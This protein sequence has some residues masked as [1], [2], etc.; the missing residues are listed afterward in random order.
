MS[1][2]DIKGQDRAVSFL[3]STVES[4]RTAH[5]YIF[6]GPAGVG[7]RFAAIKFAMAIQC[8]GRE[9]PCGECVPCR[10]IEKNNHPDVYIL[11]LNG[12]KKRDDEKG[13][14]GI[15]EIREA[16]RSIGLKPYES[17]KKVYIIDGA[18]HM[19][20]EASN[21]LLKTLEEPPSD[22][23]LILIA[24]G[25]DRL[26]PT[27]V[28]RA[29][30]L[31][32]MPLG[33]GYITDILTRFHKVEGSRARILSRIS[34]GSVGK[35]LEYNREDFFRKRENLID[36]L[37]KKDVL[38]IDFDGMPKDELKVQLEIML[39]WYR[40]VLAAK[41]GLEDADML[42]N[43]DC[44]EAIVQSAKDTEFGFLYEAVKR[45]I[46]TGALLDQSANV[47]LAMTALGVGLS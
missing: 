39:A 42:V 23:V 9:R 22:S 14:V 45:V 19:T 21:A 26:L 29:Q 36:A 32:F 41:A 4:G 11:G 6:F 16:I 37:K 28:S 12:L 35:A 18:E 44:H 34:C 30:H 33:A 5:A 2:R 27:I 15:D 1:F 10:K 8:R 24:S 31:K 43:S 40:D 7:K 25:L 3:K 38:R 17:E 13:Y 20:E 46:S 47:K